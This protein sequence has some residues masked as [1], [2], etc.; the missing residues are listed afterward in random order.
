VL[1]DAALNHSPRIRFGQNFLSVAMIADIRDRDSNP[2]DTGNS[3]TT[4]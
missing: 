1:K 4:G 3:T 2:A